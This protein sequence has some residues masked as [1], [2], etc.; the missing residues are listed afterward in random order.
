MSLR[1][2]VA[3]TLALPLRAPPSPAPLGRDA[4]LRMAAHKVPGP[5]G[6]NAIYYLV[7][8]VTVSA[9][10]YYTYKAV[11]SEQAKHTEYVT[12]FKEETKAELQ[13][14]Q[15]E[16]ARAEPEGPGAPGAGGEEA[17]GV[18]AAEP[19]AAA[20]VPGEPSAPPGAE[21]AAAGAEPEP[22]P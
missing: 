20:G 9:G 12:H 5:S 13:P 18:A 3:K 21:E 17:E 8:G 1:R 16:A 10:G 15:G 7:V 4:P 11:V 2:A 22:E 6:A 14:L 19:G